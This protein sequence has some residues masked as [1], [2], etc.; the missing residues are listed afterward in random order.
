MEPIRGDSRGDANSNVECVEE[1]T[2]NWK[3]NFST[4]C[5]AFYVLKRL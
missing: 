4:A 3:K 2:K 1:G 5:V